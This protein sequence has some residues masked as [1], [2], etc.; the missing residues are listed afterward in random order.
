MVRQVNEH[1]IARPVVEIIEG[2]RSGERI[3]L[4]NN[5]DLSIVKALNPRGQGKKYLRY[6]QLARPANAPF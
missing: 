5:G 2:E 3:D 4:S 1:D 6:L